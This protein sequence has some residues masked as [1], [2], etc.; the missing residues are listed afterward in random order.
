ME[1][2]EKMIERHTEEIK[3]LQENCNHLDLNDWLP[4]MWAPGHFWGLARSCKTCG[5]IIEQKQE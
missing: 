1:K 3:K 4:F 5:K 2:Y